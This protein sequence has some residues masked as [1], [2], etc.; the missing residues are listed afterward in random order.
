M[1]QNPRSQGG[2]FYLAVT[3]VSQRI[4]MPLAMISEAWRKKVAGRDCSIPD[5][6]P[7]LAIDTTLKQ[8]SGV[9][10]HPLTSE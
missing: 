8:A 4:G 10:F 3:R 2:H 1:S 5:G 7:A 9:T 6:P